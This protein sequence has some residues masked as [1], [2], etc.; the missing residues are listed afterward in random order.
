MNTTTS[1][2]R[3]AKYSADPLSSS[4]RDSPAS[5]VLLPRGQHLGRDAR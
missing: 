3:N 4:S 1:A 2:S 5:A